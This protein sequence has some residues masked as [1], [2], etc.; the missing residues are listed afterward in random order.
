MIVYFANRSLEILGQASTELPEGLTIKEDK[1][2]EDVETGLASFEGRIPFN[3]ETK[4]FCKGLVAPGNYVLRSVGNEHEFYT[5]INSE[6]DT[7]DMEVF[8]YAEDAGLD[9]L[10][11]VAIK[12]PD[13]EFTFKDSTFTEW[14]N[15]YISDTGWEIGRNASAGDTTKVSPEDAKVD[16][17]VTVTERLKDLAA[18][19][20]FGGYEISYSFEMA[21]SGFKILHKYVNIDKKRGADTGVQLRLNKEVDKIRTTSTIENIATSLLIY[22]NDGVTLEPYIGRTYEEGKFVIANQY[23]AEREMTHACLQSVLALQRWGRLVNGQMRHITKPFSVDSIELDEI[24]NQ[25]IKELKK[26]GDMEVNYEID[27]VNLPESIRIGDYVYIVDESAELFLKTRVLKLETSI[28]E[29][30][31]IATLGDYLIQSHGISQT[32][33]SLATQFESFAGK[34]IY[35]TWTAYADDP[36][37]TNISLV[38]LP[39]SMYLGI[40]TLQKNA[41]P[42]ITNPTVFKWTV[43]EATSMLQFNTSYTMTGVIAH[44]SAHVY[45]GNKEITEEYSDD[46]FKWYRK[47]ELGEVFIGRGKNID[48]DTETMDFGGHVVCEFATYTEGHLLDREG[49]ILADREGNRF[50]A[51]F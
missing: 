3:I 19:E 6:F 18:N 46:Y 2:V 33:R 42:D 8:F 27:I 11:E 28:E 35:Y 38:Q 16:S 34:Q 31:K 49:N 1:K 30:K 36:E 10:N 4:A 39:T 44:F 48:V 9:L 7:E 43:L 14:V 13:G 47:T 21:P 32:V 40:A 24:V 26:I 5:I 50:V 45:R 41:T 20:K 23:F 25:G 29:M 12:I 17:E 51:R 22:G 37:G 15:L